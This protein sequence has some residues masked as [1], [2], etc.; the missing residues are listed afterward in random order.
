MYAQDMYA[1]ACTG[2]VVNCKFRFMFLCHCSSRRPPTLIMCLAQRLGASLLG[3]PGKGQHEVSIISPSQSY[4]YY[5][6]DDCW[7]YTRFGIK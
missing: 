7:S 5:F 4:Q 1:C 6:L 3:Y 2:C